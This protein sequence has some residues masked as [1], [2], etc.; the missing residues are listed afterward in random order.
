MERWD[1]T[2]AITENA[3]YGS[4]YTFDTKNITGN[5]KWNSNLYR[6]PEQ[7]DDGTSFDYKVS[8]AKTSYISVARLKI[9]ND[10]EIYVLEYSP[11]EPSSF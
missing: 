4:T 10:Q 8:G 11:H 2:S 3:L 5:S 1:D 6:M 7:F 9:Q